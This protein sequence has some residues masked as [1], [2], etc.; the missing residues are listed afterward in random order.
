MIDPFVANKS[1]RSCFL[2]YFLKFNKNHTSNHQDLLEL[3]KKEGG[4]ERE[5]VCAFERSQVCL[6]FCR[7]SKKKDLNTSIDSIDRCADITTTTTVT[8][9]TGVSC[10]KEKRVEQK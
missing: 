9:Q 3:K 5:I 8:F 6:L 2:L 7:E 4:T 1:G 10:C